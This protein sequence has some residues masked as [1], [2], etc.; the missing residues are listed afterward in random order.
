MLIVM[1]VMGVLVMV[2]RSGNVERG[3]RGYQGLPSQLSTGT[4]F[5]TNSKGKDKLLGGLCA[6]WPS[7]DSNPRPCVRGNRYAPRVLLGRR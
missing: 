2:K 4:H 7:L 5:L 6:D 1:E 3:K